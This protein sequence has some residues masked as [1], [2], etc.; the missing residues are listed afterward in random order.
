MRGLLKNYYLKNNPQA[1]APTGFSA[2]RQFESSSGKMLL[3]GDTQ[4]TRSGSMAELKKSRQGSQDI[5]EDESRPKTKEEQ[6]LA[7][8]REK[9]RIRVLRAAD[10]R[11]HWISMVANDPDFIQG[12]KN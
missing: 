4:N 1:A 2:T 12:M 7:R 5:I 3:G 6:K 9:E 10:R 11:E 8:F